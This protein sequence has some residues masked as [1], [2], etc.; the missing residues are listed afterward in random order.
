MFRVNGSLVTA[1]IG[2]AM[3]VSACSRVSNPDSGEANA[4]YIALHLAYPDS[5]AGRQ[6][7]QHGDSA[8]Y[9]AR[10]PILSDNGLASVDALARPG[11]SLIL[12]V[13]CLP[14]ACAHFAA[15]TGQHVGSQLAVVVASQV[16]GLAQIAM[17]VGSRG[18]LTIA[19]DAFGADA[20]RIAQQ[21]RSRWPAQ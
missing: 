5:A 2:G 13:H 21:V 11:K 9:L 12:E 15:T 1:V 17:P 10:D 14:A 4:P 6:R 19:V 20:E 7:A 18:S 8:I 3:A 16:R